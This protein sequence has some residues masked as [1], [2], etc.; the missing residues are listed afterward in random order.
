MKTPFGHDYQVTEQKLPD[1][2]VN[3][4]PQGRIGKNAW[5]SWYHLVP[6]KVLGGWSRLISSAL[7]EQVRFGGYQAHLT[8]KQETPFPAGKA[9]PVFYAPGKWDIFVDGKPVVL[10]A[11]GEAT[12]AFGRG[13]VAVQ[14]SPGGSVALAGEAGRMQFRRT[15]FALAVTYLPDGP[16]I[17]AQRTV[18][19]TVR[20][21]GCSGLLS[22]EQVLRMVADFGM[23]VPG[24]TGYAAQPA[25][26]KTQDTYMTW[27]I[28]A[29]KGATEIRLPK[30]D[31]LN[32]IPVEVTGMQDGCSAF[33][34]DKARP[35]GKNFRAI[36][37]LNST[38]YTQI[39]TTEGNTN[40]FIGHPV[41]SDNAAVTVHVA[42][43]SPGQWCVEAHNPTDKPLTASL[44][45]ND[46]WTLFKLKESVKLAPGSSKI[47]TVKGK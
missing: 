36:P 13:V 39:D 21:A 3:I 23:L 22:K 29:A 19:V 37:V 5:T 4:I 42:W 11:A 10:S 8:F 12:G 28:A 45:A 6:T 9:L 26:G 17:P 38:A 43:M 32:Y 47:W 44:R 25:R 7:M 24:T 35:A 27:R 14:M 1:G 40:L 31:L 15:N 2:K 33:L 18:D 20:W 46:G 16:A 30:T 34:L 41:V